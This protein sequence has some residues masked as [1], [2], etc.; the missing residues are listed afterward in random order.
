MIPLPP[1]EVAPIQIQRLAD[2]GAGLCDQTNLEPRRLQRK[3]QSRRGVPIVEHEQ[4]NATR[5]AH[6]PIARCH[7]V[8]KS[9]VGSFARAGLITR[10]TTSPSARR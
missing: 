6:F 10:P 8:G 7:V 3:R 2:H 1:A 4:K 5:H 9:A